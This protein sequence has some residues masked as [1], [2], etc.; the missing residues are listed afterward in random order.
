MG[1]VK[2]IWEIPENIKTYRR[3]EDYKGSVCYNQLRYYIIDYR[4][5][6]SI[7]SPI[8]RN[9]ADVKLQWTDSSNN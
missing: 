8:G 4:S 7:F 3:R 1:F 5:F 2:C 6:Q 9:R